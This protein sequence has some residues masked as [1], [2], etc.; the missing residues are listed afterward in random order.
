MVTFAEVRSKGPGHLFF[1]SLCLFVVTLYSPVSQINNVA[2]IL[3]GL[4]WLYTGNFK[5]LKRL[6]ANKVALFLIVYYL[7][8]M[9]T[10]LYSHNKGNGAKW[11]EYR[12]PLFYLPLFIG[13]SCITLLQ[14]Q[15]LL[16]L[17]AWATAAAAL[18][19]IMYGA[20]LS[21]STGD[22]GFLYNDNLGEMF[23]KQA[24]YFAMYGNFAIAIFLYFL[25]TKWLKEK[26]SRN[27][28][29]SS[30]VLLCVL[31]Y[32][33][34]SRSAMVVLAVMLICYVFFLIYRQKRFLTGLIL[35]F[36][37]VIGGV[38][39]AKLFPKAAARIVDF[40]NTTYQYRSLN[41]EDHFNGEIKEGNWN[42][43]NTRLAIWHCASDIIREHWL[44]GVG[45]GDVEDQ[46]QGQY[47][48][49]EFVFALKNNLNSH[50]Q[51][52]EVVVAYGL[53]GGILFFIALIGIPLYRAW[54]MKDY[55]FLFFITT[56]MVYFVT[57]VMLN[58]NQGVA[59]IAFFISLLAVNSVE[60]AAGNAGEQ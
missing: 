26:R 40:T 8:Q 31:N 53:M 29:I 16:V 19:G 56:L 38:L 48:K 49:K 41:A 11:M 24:V 36:G 46:L 59:F 55:L 7:F 3:M 18:I 35:L 9:A 20:I 45:I 43:T 60:K 34:A 1:L 44:I 6:G 32:L 12:S 17:F 23:D 22:T 15:K 2:I 13:T 14:K 37:M 54:V 25:H 58:R 30:I 27:L 39:C 51:Y 21:V 47:K 10:M 28:A 5:E 4:S 52:I 42:S 50:N 33:L 57:E